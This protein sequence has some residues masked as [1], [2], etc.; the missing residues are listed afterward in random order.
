MSATGSA[1]PFTRLAVD[2][3]GNGTVSLAEVGRWLHSIVFLPGDAMLWLLSTRAAPVASALGLG[4]ADYGGIVSAVLSCAFWLAAFIATIIA[5][6]TVAEVDR[7]IT[8][9]VRHGASAG[10]LRLR[11]A[12]ALIRQ[13]WRALC[14]GRKRADATDYA[15]ALE[16]SP[17][18]MAALRL[19][20]DLKPGYAL[21]PSEVA[22]ALGARVRATEDLLAQLRELGLL[23]RGFCAA[24]NGSAYTLTAAGR[25][26]LVFHDLSGTPQ[27][28][29][30]L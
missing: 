1:S 24:E 19:H 7:R 11:I 26:L 30:K 18:Q 12:T 29:R 25:G 22:R 3:D 20:A 27:P 17:R 9:A 2:V 10:A 15:S 6:H 23:H 28:H 13:R 8:S 5:C 14:A 4:S 16:L 21:S